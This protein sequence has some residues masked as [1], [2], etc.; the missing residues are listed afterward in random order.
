MSDTAPVF[1]PAGG[2][3]LYSLLFPFLPG[4]SRPRNKARCLCRSPPCITGTEGCAFHP[5]LSITG[6]LRHGQT[7]TH[8]ALRR[9]SCLRLSQGGKS[10]L[11]VCP[12]DR[13]LSRPAV[14]T[15]IDSIHTVSIPATPSSLSTVSEPF[16]SRRPC[17]HR[18]RFCRCEC[19]LPCL[20]PPF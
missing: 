12:A 11:C 17:R 15:F 2:K 13:C 7:V 5:Y 9:P 14:V 8:S 10:P 6:R 19:R 18:R 20:F 3:Y 1:Q 4:L 16:F